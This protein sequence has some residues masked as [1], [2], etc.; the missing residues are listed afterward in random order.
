MGRICRG[1][2]Y[3]Q[4]DLDSG[5]QLSEGAEVSVG[6]FSVPFTLRID[7]HSF[8]A[9]LF[10]LGADHHGFFAE[11]HIPECPLYHS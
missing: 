4:N 7:N 1:V 2:L 10:L 8:D 5:V 6:A 11:H 9:V 3:H